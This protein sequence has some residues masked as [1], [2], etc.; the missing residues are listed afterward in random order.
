MTGYS[1]VPL[2]KKLG[3]KSPLTLLTINAPVEYVEWLGHLPPGVTIATEAKPP[4]S[5][6]HVFATR[7]AALEKYLTACRKT[8]EPAGFVW[9][10]WPKQSANVDT[11]ITEDVIRDLALPMGFVDIKVCAVT[12]V[13]SGLK[14]VL[15][16][17]ERPS[18][19]KA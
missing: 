14:L 6:V 10:S 16:K 4:F 3:Y 12:D 8:L 15:R 5:A 13:W 9:V 7:K 18:Q 11:D 19:D 17:S 2:A 1:G